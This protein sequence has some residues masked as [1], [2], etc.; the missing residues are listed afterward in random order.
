M[1]TGMEPNGTSFH[2]TGINSKVNILTVKYHS[3]VPVHRFSTR[4]LHIVRR[5]VM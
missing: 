4:G 1:A 3:T 5:N 2:Q